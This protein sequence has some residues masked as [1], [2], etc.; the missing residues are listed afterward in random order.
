VSTGST[1][2]GAFGDGPEADEHADF[3]SAVIPG[4]PTSGPKGL[5]VADGGHNA[6]KDPAVRADLVQ[7]ALA[8]AITLR[9]DLPAQVV[10][11]IST[12]EP[13]TPRPRSP[14]SPQPTG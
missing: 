6:L 11:H 9:G 3:G 5:F 13:S 2:E 8:T 1:A 14:R 12:G 7:D 4:R 10:F